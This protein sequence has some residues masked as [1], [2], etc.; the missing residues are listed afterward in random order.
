MKTVLF[1]NGSPYKSE[2]TATALKIMK[3]TFH[4]NGIQTIWFHISNKPVRGCIG[5]GK[6]GETHRFDFNDDVCNDLI[7]SILQ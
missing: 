6:C 1:I 5:C 2:N 7:E 4:K 3:D